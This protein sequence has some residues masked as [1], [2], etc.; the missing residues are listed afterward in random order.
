MGQ[1]LP[2]TPEQFHQIPGAKIAIIGASWHSECVD[3]MI[4][5]AEKELHNCGVSPEDIQI[6]KVPGSLELPLAARV[7]FETNPAL[8]AVLTFGVVLSG[9]TTHD[10]T[11]ITSVSRGFM[12]VQDRFGKLIINEVIGVENIEDAHKRS[13]DDLFNKGVEAV[14]ATS[15]MLHWMR[16]Q[17]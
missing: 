6:H 1:G 13:G 17:D 12:D 8:D 4:A 15:E 10:E 11:V 14:Y 16:E 9:I 2:K 3:A 7:L 5:R